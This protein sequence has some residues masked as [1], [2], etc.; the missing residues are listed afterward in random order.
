MR[1]RPLVILSCVATLVFAA[2]EKK[3]T[4]AAPAPG[5]ATPTAAAPAAAAPAPAVPKPAK[6]SA[7]ERAAKLGFVKR[8]PKDAE[9]VF[10]LY[11]GNEIVGRLKKTKIW[12]LINEESGGKLNELGQS[13][14]GELGV[15]TYLGKEFFLASGNGSAA[16]FANLL[17]FSH[18]MNYFQLRGLA[19]SFAKAAK[20]GKLSGFK[21]DDKQSVEMFTNLLKDPQSGVGLL[22]H[23]QM[24]PLWIGFKVG[25]EQREKVLQQ[26]NG[27]LGML[28]SD[29]TIAKPVAFESG[30]GKFSGYKILGEGLAKQMESGREVMEQKM[31]ANLVTRIIAAVRSKNLV[32]APGIVDDY[33]VLFLGT[34][35]DECRLAKSADESLAS[36]DALGFADGYANKDIATFCY[37][38]PGVMNVIRANADTLAPMVTGIRDG[39]GDSEASGDLKDVQALLQ[40]VS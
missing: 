34:S 37:D 39:L 14:E 23:S 27:L 38:A 33:V 9:I 12:G 18:R 6:L 29:E 32:I 7:S 22:E 16:Q 21:P 17:T 10:S 8:L 13:G 20:E 2:C 1:P 28:A 31:D 25:D 3:A 40:I 36:I 15:S 30:G 24:P 26:I 5:E 11:K 19:A 35:E 4:P